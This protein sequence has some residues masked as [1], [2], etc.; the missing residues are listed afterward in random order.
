MSPTPQKPL[1][2]REFLSDNELKI[3]HNNIKELNSPDKLWIERIATFIN[4]SRV[5]KDWSDNDVDDFKI[6]VK[7]LALRFATIE[8][9]AGAT[10]LNLDSALTNVLEQISKFSKPQK[11]Q[12]VREIVERN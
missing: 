11:M 12:L 3:L 6:K 8:A 10:G 5:P 7:E 1:H 4:K 2:L 9:T